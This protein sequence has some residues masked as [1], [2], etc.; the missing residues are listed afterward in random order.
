MHYVDNDTVRQEHV[1]YIDENQKYPPV[2]SFLNLSVA[3]RVEIVEV[4]FKFYV[5][6]IFSPFNYEFIEC[7]DSEKDAKK[8]VE[9]ILN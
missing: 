1:Q 2:K 5:K 9:R 3:Q 7:F 4:G 8:Y 6:V